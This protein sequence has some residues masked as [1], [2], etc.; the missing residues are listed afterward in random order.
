MYC[1]QYEEG[2]LS[3]LG[4]LARKAVPLLASGVKLP[5]L[6][7]KQAQT[8]TAKD[9]THCVANEITNN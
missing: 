7:V 6:H 2:L 3:I 8:G 9:V 1:T 4:S 5:A